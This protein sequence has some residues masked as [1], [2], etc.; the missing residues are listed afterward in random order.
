MT[1]LAFKQIHISHAELK[2][3]VSYDAETGVISW[4]KPRTKVSVGTECGTVKP[5]G[6]RVIAIMGHLYRAHRLAWFYQTGEWPE[7]EMDHIN[8]VRSDNRFSN[9][10][11][12]SR[13]QN[14]FNKAIR[15]DSKV[16]HKNVISYPNWGIHYAR[17]QV[18]GTTHSF[19]PFKTVDEAAAVAIEKRIELHREF[20]HH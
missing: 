6:Y 8:G 12:A 5:N 15:K 4:K 3:L 18:R 1:K 16:G 9:L 13:S 14:G 10:R 19:G 20:A 11:L 7:T 17:F 2:E